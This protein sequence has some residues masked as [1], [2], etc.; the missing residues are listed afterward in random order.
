MSL[1]GKK[2]VV[3]G[4]SSGIGKATAKAAAEAGAHVIIGSRS[5]EHLSR[6]KEE[7]IGKIDY[8]AIDVRDLRGMDYCLEQISPFDHLVFTAVEPYSAP[9]L[10]TSIEEARKTFDV[11]FWG[12]FA[13]AQSAAP[14][15]LE[16]GSITLFSGLAAHRPVRGLSV[17][18]AT[19][20]AVEALVRTLAIELS[21]VRVNAVCPGT[22][23]TH[24]VS[25]EKLAKLEAALPV[26]RIGQPEDVAQAVLFLMQSPYT[27][28]TVLHVDGGNALI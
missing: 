4:G 19:N 8:C 9:F 11:K 7:I 20:G 24:E 15:L 3:I 10:Q 16:G 14:S 17:L 18:A 1:Q 13:A 22:I 27:T 26:R 5:E 23:K 28:G 25:E 21:P 2:V 12:Q 6:A